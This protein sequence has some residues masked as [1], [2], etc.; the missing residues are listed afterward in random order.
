MTF[1][2]ERFTCF[3]VTLGPDLLCKRCDYKLQPLGK[4]NNLYSLSAFNMTDAFNTYFFLAYNLFTFVSNSFI[5]L[6]LEYNCCTMF[7][8]FLLFDRVD[9]ICVHIH[10]LPPGPPSRQRTPPAPLPPLWV[11]SGHQ[12]SSSVN[13][14][15]PLAACFTRGSVYMSVP[16]SQFI[17]PSPC[18]LCVHMFVPYAYVSIPVLE[19]GSSVSF[20]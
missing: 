8:Y 7:C 14:A 4:N 17:P 13:S 18:P 19:I 10:A 1:K 6:K 3:L 16:L 15:F 11:T 12:A 2:K 9:Q 20:F 5:F